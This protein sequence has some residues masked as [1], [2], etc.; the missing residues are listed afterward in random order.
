MAISTHKVYANLKR[1]DEVDL[2]TGAIYRQL[3]QDVIAESKISLG[4]RMVIANR[5]AQA[6]YFLG[7]RTASSGDSY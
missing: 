6:N 7:M 2:V 5:L 3:A 4:R 1:I